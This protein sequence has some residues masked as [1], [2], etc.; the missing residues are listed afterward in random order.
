MEMLRRDAEIR[1]IILIMSWACLSTA[2][3]NSQNDTQTKAYL[4]WTAAVRWVPKPRGKTSGDKSSSFHCG[5]SFIAKLWL[6]F[7]LAWENLQRY[8]T[9]TPKCLK[10]LTLESL[11]GLC[12]SQRQCLHLL[13][14]QSFLERSARAVSRSWDINGLSPPVWA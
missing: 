12:F 13:R 9:L 2:A 8:G 1:K 6:V 14:C 5:E 3:S 4:L 10:I 11:D 7:G